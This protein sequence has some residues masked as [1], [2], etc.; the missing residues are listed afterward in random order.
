MLHI[1]FKNKKLFTLALALNLA[2]FWMG[3]VYGADKMIM[4]DGKIEEGELIEYDSQRKEY[5]FKTQFGQIPYQE[6]K[7]KKIEMEVRQDYKDALDAISQGLWQRAEVK[8]KSL[9]ERY[10]GANVPWVL[11]AAGYYAESLEQQKKPSFEIEKIYNEIIKLY[12]GSIY[13]LKGEIGKA[14]AKAG[15]APDEALATLA[16]IE[17]RLKKEGKI[18]A[19][20]D[21]QTMSIMSEI[22][23][24]KGEIFVEKDPS[25][26]LEAYLKVATLYFYPE[27]RSR[28]AQEKADELRSKHKGIFVK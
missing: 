5:L 27:E 23:F 17:E 18:T 7:V 16:S 26:A 8:L 12:P 2:F 19:M 6:A 3:E 28:L 1:I 11:E 25:A 13:Q 10:R 21:K 4:A 9:W 14:K 15:F 24:T 22:Y 20:P